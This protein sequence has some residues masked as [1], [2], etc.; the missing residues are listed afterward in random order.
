MIGADRRQDVQRV[1][2][3]M[4]QQCRTGDGEVGDAPSTNQIAEI[5]QAL[6]APLPLRVSRPHCVVFRDIQVHGL[7]RQVRQQGRQACLHLRGGILDAL[8]L[9]FTGDDGQQVTNQRGGVPWVP[10]QHPLQPW[11][12]EVGQRTPDL[13]TGAGQCPHHLAVEMAQMRQRLPFDELQQADMQGASTDLKRQQVFPAGGHD[14]PG[15]PYARSLGQMTQRRML[16][17]QLADGVVAM[18]DLEHIAA[19]T[20]GFGRLDEKVAVLLA[21][22]FPNGGFQPVM[23]AH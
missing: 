18:A 20:S 12:L 3:G 5:D 2:L 21:T 14:Q 13:G 9:L 11:M 10:L 22:Q 4:V 6:Q 16:R 19:T 23:L 7:H 8:A 15:H 1:A 17:L